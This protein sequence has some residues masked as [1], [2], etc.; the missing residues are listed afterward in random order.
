PLITRGANNWPCDVRPH[1]PDARSLNGCLMAHFVRSSS[2]SPFGY[3]VDRRTG[4]GSVWR[5]QIP[6]DSRRSTALWGGNEL[7]VRSRNPDVVPNDGFREVRDDDLRVLSL[8]SHTDGTSIV[9]IGHF[10][11][12]L[13]G[14]RADE[15][16]ASDVYYVGNIFSSFI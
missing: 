10:P 7:W 16:L 9:E 5:I 14:R 12:H 13:A 1:L 2:P 15:Y 4:P 11:A 3:D 8:L 6:F